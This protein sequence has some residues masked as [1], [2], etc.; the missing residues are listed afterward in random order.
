MGRDV[1]NPWG[2]ARVR[3]ILRALGIEA[4]GPTSND[5]VG[6]LALIRVRQHAFA[7]PHDEAETIIRNEVPFD[8]WAPVGGAS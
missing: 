1:W 4:D 7:S 3:R 6:K 5:I 8:G 2:M